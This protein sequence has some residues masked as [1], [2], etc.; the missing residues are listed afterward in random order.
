ME[1]PIGTIKD[2]HKPDPEPTFTDEDN[3]GVSVQQ[4]DCDDHN[5]KAS[6]DLNEVCD[7]V[8]N[9]CDGVADVQDGVN[10]CHRSAVF[11]QEMQADV[12]IVLDNSWNTQPYWFLAADGAY[13]MARHLA[14]EN[15]HTHIGVLVT[16]MVSS[17]GKL[18]NPSQYD[19]HFLYGDKDPALNEDKLE[20]WLYETMTDR[21]PVWPNNDPNG[22]TRAAI[23]AATDLSE[24]WNS[25]FFRPGVALSVV[26][27]SQREDGSS[28]STLPF[29]DELTTFEGEA[30]TFHA[31]TQTDPDG[32]VYGTAP[33]ASSIIALVQQTGGLLESVCMTDYRGF[34]SSVG[35]SIASDALK[36]SFLLGSPAR[37]TSLS[38]TVEEKSGAQYAW[39]DFALM[40]DGRTLVFPN[41]PPPA[42]STIYVD[43]LKE[44]RED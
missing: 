8:D 6:P 12:L 37:P 14:D 41:L 25:G 24:S 26:I 36:T 18:Q 20:Q 5:P 16:D 13:Q 29:L 27:I 17:A 33:V 9:N 44:Y 23:H 10:K 15:S 43:Y 2:R 40:G 4:L 7:G 30:P 11:E 22:G 1:V 28:P 19:G 35:Q 3:D 21:D 34:M 42:G 31:I 39:E 32:C 38:V